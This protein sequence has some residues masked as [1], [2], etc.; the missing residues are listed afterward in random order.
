[1]PFHVSSELT[2]CSH[3]LCSQCPSRNACQTEVTH[4]LLLGR[5]ASSFTSLL[6]SS[7]DTDASLGHLVVIRD[8]FYCTVMHPDGVAENIP[9]YPSSG[10]TAYR[11]G[12]KVCFCENCRDSVDC[13]R[14]CNE[15]LVAS[16]HRWAC[17]ICERLI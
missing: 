15:Y 6:S 17:W 12:L 8:H 2:D 4:V 16:I 3:R 5:C 13:I 14:I 11:L 7:S 9:V 10:F 1:V